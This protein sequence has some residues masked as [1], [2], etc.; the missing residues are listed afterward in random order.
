MSLC[1]KLP[2]THR[3]ALIDPIVP[4]DEDSLVAVDLSTAVQ[5][6]QDLLVT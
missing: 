3:E 4:E 2:R 6:W 1:R 5:R